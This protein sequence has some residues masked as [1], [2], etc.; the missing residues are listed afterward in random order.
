MRRPGRSRFGRYRATHPVTHDDVSGRS[1]RPA[2]DAE[3]ARFLLITVMLMA[4]GYRGERD[5]LRRR[6]CRPFAP[7]SI[8]RRGTPDVRPRER[9]GETSRGTRVG[10][11]DFADWRAQSSAS[12]T[13]PHT[14]RSASISCT[15]VP[16]SGW[17][18]SRVRELRARPRRRSVGGSLLRERRRHAWQRAVVVVSDRLWRTSPRR[19]GDAMGR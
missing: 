18:P 2:D 6:E 15:A 1:L 12:P 19:A 9:A 11:P 14:H 17:S 5:S 7:A 8:S 4:L 3:G 13:S 10:L 16:P